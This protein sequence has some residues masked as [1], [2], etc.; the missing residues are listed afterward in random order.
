MYKKEP[1]IKA[2]DYG[3]PKG[4]VTQQ[5]LILTGTELLEITDLIRELAMETGRHD[6]LPTIEKIERPFT[7]ERKR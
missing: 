5:V 2:S 1:R 4:Q 7:Q 6:L 3:I